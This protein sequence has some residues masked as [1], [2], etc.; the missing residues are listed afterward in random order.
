MEVGIL[1]RVTFE[2]TW[3]GGEGVSYSHSMAIL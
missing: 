1:E 3:K 2:Q